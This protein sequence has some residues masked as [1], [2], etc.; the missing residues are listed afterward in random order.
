MTWTDEARV[1]LAEFEIR[2]DV[3]VVSIEHHEEWVERVAD[4][5]RQLDAE[6]EAREH[7]ED[8]ARRLHKEKMAQ[9]ER[10]LQAESRLTAAP[11]LLYELKHIVR[12]L[13]AAYENSGI[14]IPGLATLNAAR[15][16]IKKAEAK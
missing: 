13:E 15:A 10:A 3:E 14:T 6:R 12:L 8:D 7:A 11:E 5:E 16:A 1:A 9:L 2:F 4:L